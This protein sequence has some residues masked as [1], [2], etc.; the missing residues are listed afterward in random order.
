MGVGTSRP[1]H[2]PSRARSGD[3][4]A[5]APEPSRALVLDRGTVEA[6][7]A[8]RAIVEIGEPMPVAGALAPERDSFAQ[9]GR[10]AGEHDEE[11]G[12]AAGRPERSPRTAVTQVNRGRWML[13]H[14]R[15]PVLGRIARG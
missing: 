14:C 4:L 7:I 5:Q 3:R 13:C 8:E 12:G 9:T 1:D 10:H 11:A 15:F 2:P 6:H